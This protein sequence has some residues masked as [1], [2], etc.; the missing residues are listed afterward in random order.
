MCEPTARNNKKHDRTDTCKCRNVDGTT[1]RLPRSDPQGTPPVCCLGKLNPSFFV[2]RG[3]PFMCALVDGP[4]N[5]SARTQTPERVLL[6]NMGDNVNTVNRTRCLAHVVP[7][8]DYRWFALLQYRKSSQR[9]KSTG[10]QSIY[11]NKLFCLIHLYIIYF[12]SSSL[13]VLSH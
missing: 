4:I 11:I 3:F 13:T 12:A 10:I 1:T 2:C 8:A 7:L 9:S 6:S 5:E